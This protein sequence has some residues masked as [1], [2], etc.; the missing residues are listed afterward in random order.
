M[1]II[2]KDMAFS[3]N[4]AIGELLVVAKK[5]I[6]QDGDVTKF[7]KMLRKPKTAAQGYAIGEVIL[8]DSER[9][10]YRIAERPQSRMAAGD[11]FPTQFVRTER[12][13]FFQNLE[14]GECFP[15]SKDMYG[16]NLGP[17]VGRY[18]ARTAP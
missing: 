6:P 16:D 12:I 9:A 2:P 3:E 13:E 11:W 1:D 7:V 5:R 8:R 14:S 10:N 18:A 17:V 15:T 4:T